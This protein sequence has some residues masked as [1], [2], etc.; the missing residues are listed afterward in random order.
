MSLGWK[1]FSFFETGELAQCS[2]PEN[3]TCTCSSSTS[4]YCGTSAG[5]VSFA[6]H[7]AVTFSKF[8]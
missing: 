2:L 7:A 3:V 5:E 6:L 8:Y 1:K 4:L